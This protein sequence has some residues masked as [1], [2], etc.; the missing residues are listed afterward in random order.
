MTFTKLIS[1]NNRDPKLSSAA[2]LATL[3][4]VNDEKEK[5]RVTFKARLEVVNAEFEVQNGRKTVVE[6]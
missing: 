2:L 6:K 5:Q 4:K 1:F 3:A